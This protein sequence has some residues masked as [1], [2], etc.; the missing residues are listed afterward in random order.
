MLKD[1]FLT[2]LKTS[3]VWRYGLSVVSVPAP[4][5]A[6]YLLQPYVLRTPLFFLAIMVSSCMGG[7]GPGLLAAALHAPTMREVNRRAATSGTF[8]KRVSR[9]L[10]TEELTYERS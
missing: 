2:R 3:A 10:R 5:A 8:W 9:V 4:L 1:Y 6:T 7:T